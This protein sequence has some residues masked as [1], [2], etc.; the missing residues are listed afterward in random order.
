MLKL[1]H[2]GGSAG[3]PKLAECLYYELAHISFPVPE[4]M[5]GE[6][7]YTFDVK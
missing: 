7:T 1:K 4:T 5:V 3:D 6:L 2:T